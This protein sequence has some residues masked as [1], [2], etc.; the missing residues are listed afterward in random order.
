MAF[1][2]LVVS[3]AFELWNSGLLVERSYGVWSSYLPQL[4]CALDRAP[5]LIVTVHGWRLVED[6][7]SGA[8]MHIPLAPRTE[9]VEEQVSDSLTAP[10]AA[11]DGFAYIAVFTLRGRL[12]LR[13]GRGGARAISRGRTLEEAKVNATEV[14]EG[15][16]A[17]QVAD[18]AAGAIDALTP[19]SIHPFTGRSRSVPST[20]RGG[21]MA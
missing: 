16:L 4:P 15:A 7:V 13:A 18:P 10:V 1:V 8:A 21:P 3:Q 19:A 14:L 12:A 5:L 17:W 11:R 6:P 9:N 2:A 20:T